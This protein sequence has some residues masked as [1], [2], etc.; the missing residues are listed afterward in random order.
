MGRLPKNHHYLNNPNLPT[1]QAQFEYTPEMVS[2]L[3]KCKENVLHFAENYFYIIS[4][5]DGRQKIPLHTYQRKAL[6]MIR[7]ERF[8]LL[9]FSRQSGKKLCVDTLVATTSGYVRNGDLKDGDYIL[10]EF[11]DPVKVLKAHPITNEGKAYK[12]IFDNGEVVYACSEHLWFTVSDR[13]FDGGV[14]T[15]QEIADTFE[16]NHRIPNFKDGGEFSINSIEEVPS[17]PMRCITVDN[18]TGL[19]LITKNNIP[20]HNTTM[21]TIFCLWTAIFQS[22][23]RILL[24]ANKESTAKEIFKRIK[25]A[26]EELP[27]WIKSGVAQWGMESMSLANGSAIEISTTTGTAAR[28][29]S[30]NLLF[31]DEIDFIPSELL[32]EFWAS[33][34]PIISSS[35]KSKIIMASTPRDTS[36]LFYQLYSESLKGENDWKTMKIIWSDIP[37]RD[38]KWKNQTIRS[39]GDAGAFQREFCCEFDQVGDSQIDIAVCEELRQGA[40]TPLYVLDDGNYCLWENPDPEK[41]YVAGVDIAEGVGKD[42]SCIQILDITDPRY[43]QQV[44][45]YSNNKISPM[46]FTPRLREI[47]QN[48]GDPLALIERNA[49]G[50]QVVDNLKKNFSYD[51]IVS[52]GQSKATYKENYRTAQLGIMSHTN[53]K[54]K[55]IHNQRYWIQTMK[56]I[57]I[58]DVKTINELKDFVRMKNGTY[59]AKA[60]CNDD[61]VM[62]LAWALMILSDE[63]VDRYF[64][65]LD[66]D[67]NGKPLVIKPMDYGVKYFMNPTSIYTQDKTGEGGDAMPT[68]L[69]SVMQSEN[70]EMDDLTAGGWTKLGY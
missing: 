35:K 8:N 48:W 14:R 30:S 42:Y 40:R 59:S 65:V 33:V 25:M 55:A 46:E 41:I 6:R 31:I 61:R 17:V 54:F 15:T 67:E 63:L 34:Y 53:T 24:V 60:G 36:G 29:K 7:D 32:R 37:G 49:C 13:N 1:A 39:L 2:E 57:R 56:R 50:G 58:S 12:I 52:W 5:D 64:E 28:G 38:E 45:V 51:N 9:I 20:T 43:I 22:D 44:A 3:K 4:V 62:S 10:N 11:G 23:Q 69:G 16:D 27:N 70:I 26:Y 19:Y 21:A 47:L 66:K 18:P 68:F